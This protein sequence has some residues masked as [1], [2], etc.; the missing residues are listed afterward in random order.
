[1]RSC[2]SL[3]LPLQLSGLHFKPP[4]PES[5]ET[6]TC[7]WLAPTQAGKSS[8][9]TD[10]PGIGLGSMMASGACRTYADLGESPTARSDFEGPSEIALQ[11]IVTRR[12]EASWLGHQGHKWREERKGPPLLAGW[13]FA[14]PPPPSS[15]WSL[16]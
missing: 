8:G 12:P 16:F 2:A 13:R 5:A 1:M 4:S 14:S 11:S 6:P 7:V 3:S 15:H 9:S 10:A